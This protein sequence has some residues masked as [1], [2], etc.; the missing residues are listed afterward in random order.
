M[1]NIYYLQI[2]L[3]IKQVTTRKS[4][5]FCI[6]DFLQNLK[7]L[8]KLILMPL[9]LV[10]DELTISTISLISSSTSIAKI[11]MRLF[12]SKKAALCQL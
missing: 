8:H 1:N 6:N 4:L 7:Y 3:K 2:I 9:Y 12:L 10:R 5:A 11:L